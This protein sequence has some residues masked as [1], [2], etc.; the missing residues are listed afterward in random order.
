MRVPGL[1]C[2]TTCRA[3]SSPHNRL[4][5]DTPASQEPE[6]TLTQPHSFWSKAE[7]GTCLSGADVVTLRSQKNILANLG[8]TALHN[9]IALRPLS[10]IPLY[11]VL[12]PL[13]VF[14]HFSAIASITLSTLWTPLV[15]LY[16][17]STFLTVP[18]PL[19]PSLV[20][21]HQFPLINSGLPM[22]TVCPT[23]PGQI[24]C[25]DHYFWEYLFGSFIFREKTSMI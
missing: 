25:I 3:A 20:T 13:G 8:V 16:F 24:Y 1:V 15:L 18:L 21:L 23:G 7:E 22:Q 19:S 12:R 14:R 11:L 5:M 9:L 17:C 2:I 4:Q 10:Y 6:L